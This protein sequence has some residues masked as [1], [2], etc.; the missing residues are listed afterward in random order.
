MIYQPSCQK[1]IGIL[2]SMAVVAPRSLIKFATLNMCSAVP[3]IIHFD[4][5]SRET[6]QH[7]T[8]LGAFPLRALPLCDHT[9]SATEPDAAAPGLLCTS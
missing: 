3:C 8:K 5:F 7:K 4:S 9:V 2:D 6:Q 1:V